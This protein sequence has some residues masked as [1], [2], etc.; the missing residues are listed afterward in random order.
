MCTAPLLLFINFSCFIFIT[1]RR[2]K[3]QQHFSCQEYTGLGAAFNMST[4]AF[5]RS[6]SS[7]CP[8]PSRVLSPLNKTVLTRTRRRANSPLTPSTDASTSTVLPL[9]TAATLL[10]SLSPH[11]PSAAYELTINLRPSPTLQLN[12]LRGRLFLPHASSS[13]NKSPRLYLFAPSALHSFC[14]SLPG[15]TRVGA[16]E[17]FEELS[18]GKLGPGEIDKLLTTKEMLRGFGKVARLLGPRGLMPSEKRGTVCGSTE[19]ELRKA[20]REALGGTDWKG[21]QRGVV[22]AGAYFS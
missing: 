8:T 9:A 14:S 22:R 21:D 20:V 19:S 2:P 17:L 4:P 7:T 1:S 11:T 3:A 13:P 6:F 12:A 16:E 18:S 15:V 5:R 10:S